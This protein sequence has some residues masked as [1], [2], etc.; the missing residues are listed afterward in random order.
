MTNFC[1]MIWAT[2]SGEAKLPGRHLRHR[3]FRC[4]LRKGQLK[5]NHPENSSQNLRL[6]GGLIKPYKGIIQTMPL[7]GA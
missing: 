5:S 4:S 6:S 3:L 7:K 2:A 1:V